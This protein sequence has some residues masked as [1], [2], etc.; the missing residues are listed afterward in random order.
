M[1]YLWWRASTSPDLPSFGF[2]LAGSVG[3]FLFF[4]RRRGEL[5]RM[6]GLELNKANDGHVAVRT[7]A[8]G[9]G[10]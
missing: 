9:H 8:K 2:C 3:D 7:L 10:D 1:F 4:E 6:L 5:P